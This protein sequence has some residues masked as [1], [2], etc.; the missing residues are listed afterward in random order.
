MHNSL[1]T[2]ISTHFSVV[3]SWLIIQMICVVPIFSQPSSTLAFKLNGHKYEIPEDYLVRAME[4]QYENNLKQQLITDLEDFASDNGI[5]SATVNVPQNILLWY[6]VDEEG[7]SDF[8][9]NVELDGDIKLNGVY[10]VCGEMC[11]LIIVNRE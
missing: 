2:S 7:T 1:K 5:S 9:I 10:D 4:E 11:V 3:V 6:T 8:I